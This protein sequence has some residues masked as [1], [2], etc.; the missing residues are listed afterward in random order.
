MTNLLWALIV[1]GGG[2]VNSGDLR[3]P[4]VVSY[5]RTLQGCEN[6]KKA[7][8]EMYPASDDPRYRRRYGPR[9]MRCVQSDFVVPKS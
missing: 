8:D 5:H 6:T 7:V 1:I 4:Y 9:D 3:Q 2:Y